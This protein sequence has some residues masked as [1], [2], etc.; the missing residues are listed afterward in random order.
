ME[1]S[2]ELQKEIVGAR[3]LYLTEVY[4]IKKAVFESQHTFCGYPESDI[5]R[6]LRTKIIKKIFSQDIERELYDYMNYFT[7]IGEEKR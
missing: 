5:K 2:A 6:V 3:K 1:I 4:K 7:D